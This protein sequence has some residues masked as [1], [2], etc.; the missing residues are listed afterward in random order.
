MECGGGPCESGISP[1]TDG[2]I[3]TQAPYLAAA[4]EE[5]KGL[6]RCVHF[7]LLKLKD[8]MDCALQLATQQS[9]ES[10]D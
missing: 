3:P 10:E 2:N 5:G 1:A 8:K 9:W 4:K 7:A 6:S